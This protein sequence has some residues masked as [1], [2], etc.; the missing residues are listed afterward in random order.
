MLHRWNLKNSRSAVPAALVLGIVLSL[1]ATSRTAAA[2]HPPAPSPYLADGVCRPHRTTWGYSRTHW[3]PWPADQARQP[4]PEEAAATEKEPQLSPFE[5]PNPMQEDLRG[6]TKT[7]PSKSGNDAAIE[8]ET[9]A[10]SGP[11]EQPTEEPAL[12]L[13]QD[14]ALPGLDPQGHLQGPTAPEKEKKVAHRPRTAA[15]R[16]PL[17]QE[18]AP[19]ALPESLRR[20][21][22]AL[23]ARTVIRP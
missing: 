5:R 7:A 17:D 13:P 1:A 16:S 14:E 4:T 15:P 18:D 20:V 8:T 23:H 22:L 3:R 12:D 2:G 19:P 10:A 21:S 6:R 11:V 9:P